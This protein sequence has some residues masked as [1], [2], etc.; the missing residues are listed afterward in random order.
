MLRKIRDEVHR[1]DITFHRQ[2]RKKDMT[3]SIF[4]DIPGMGP[5]RIQKLWKEF[6]SLESIQKTSLKE[7]EKQTGFSK[8]LCSAILN[9][10]GSSKT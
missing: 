6:E 4:E 3:K 5:K 8:K 9:C 2:S 1:Y 10:S 7:L